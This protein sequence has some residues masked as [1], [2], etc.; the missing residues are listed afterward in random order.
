M[1][2]GSWGRSRIAWQSCTPDARSRSGLSRHCSTTLAIPIRNACS[3]LGLGA[4]AHALGSPRLPARCLHPARS[5]MAAR[6]RRAVSLHR[7]H[8]AKRCPRG[9]GSATVAWAASSM[10]APLAWRLTESVLRKWWQKRRR[11]GRAM[12]LDIENLSVCYRTRRG[13]LNAVDD[14]SLGVAR[15]ETLGLVGESGCGKSSLG[16]AIV[17]LVDLA[18]GT[19]RLDGKDING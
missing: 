14:L 19:V 16:R 18:G 9:V 1:I 4:I 17:G 13:V 3:P 15:G 12:L 6:S 11:K 5:Q 8:A 2:S 10:Q 7:R